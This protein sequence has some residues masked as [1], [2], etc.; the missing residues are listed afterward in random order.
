TI[1]YDLCFTMDIYAAEEYLQQ[2][3]LGPDGP[4]DPPP[5]DPSSAPAAGPPVAQVSAVPS[6]SRRSPSLDPVVAPSSTLNELGR[7]DASTSPRPGG[8]SARGSSSRDDS[9]RSENAQWPSRDDRE[10]HEPRR[11]SRSPDRRSSWTHGDRERRSPSPRR[12]RPSSPRRASAYPLRWS[13]TR[14][15]VRER[16]PREA[17]P[18][19]RELENWIFVGNLPLTVAERFIYDHLTGI[20]I[21]V[22]DVFLAQKLDHPKRFAYVAVRRAADLRTACS[23]LRRVRVDGLN[24]LAKPFVDATTGSS[25]PQVS[26]SEY[27]RQYV[28]SDRQAQRSPDERKL[29]LFMLHLSRT[30]RPSDVLNFLLRCLRVDEIGPIEVKPVGTNVIAFVDIRDEALCRRAI[31]QLDGECFCGQAVRV[32]WLELAGK[33]SRSMRTS[34]QHPPDLDGA[35]VN[36]APLKM[37]RYDQLA[38]A[39]AE[40]QDDPQACSAPVVA[41]TATAPITPTDASTRAG[42]VAVSAP[43]S[44]SPTSTVV[45]SL[46]APPVVVQGAPAPPTTASIDRDVDRLRS[47]GLSDEQ[48]VAVQQ[49]W[50]PVER[51]EVGPSS[52]PPA[53]RGMTV[54]VDFGCVNEED[55]KL[56]LSVNA[57][58]PA[59]PD[60]AASQ[61]R[62]SAFLEAQAGESRDYYTVFFAK[63]AEFNSSSAA[64]AA[65]AHTVAEEAR[66]DTSTAMSVDER[67]VKREERV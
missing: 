32:A 25:I 5:V 19:P 51:A 21:G 8:P 27:K 63:L 50:R 16:A 58:E 56:A 6:S 60:D 42:R 48:V 13:P 62:Y 20:G 9:R 55:A 35:A 43:T 23:S 57:H 37:N 45:G 10:R 31:R 64:F 41:A 1:S 4:L 29:G 59:F 49:L 7:Q 26:N 52:R 40:Q 54:K 38:K 34:S 14:Q 47:I 3:G 44:A 66:R 30:A 61:A 24:V 2:H 46:A 28:G 17:T 22:D 12:A 67:V 53:E 65:K 33:P 18:P 15:D 39:A 36:R 11:R